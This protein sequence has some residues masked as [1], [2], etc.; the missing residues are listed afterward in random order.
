VREHLRCGVCGDWQI[1]SCELCSLHRLASPLVGHPVEGWR[2]HRG[3]P[4]QVFVQH[5]P[6]CLCGLDRQWKTRL[7]T[8][9]NVLFLT[10]VEIFA[11]RGV[12]VWRRG[13]PP[14]QPSLG[15]TEVNRRPVPSRIPHE[16]ALSGNWRVVAVVLRE[17]ADRLLTISLWVWR[18]NERKSPLTVMA[19]PTDRRTLPL[20]G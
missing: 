20:R 8:I 17:Y 12:R 5:R 2:D 1:H 18:T 7:R 4:T 6:W 14:S 16:A 9:I 15:V 10:F 19:P 13:P 3:D 11:P